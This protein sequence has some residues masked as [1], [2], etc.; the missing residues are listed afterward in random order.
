MALA[1]VRAL[2]QY[3]NEEAEDSE[4]TDGQL[5]DILNSVNGDYNIA[6]AQVWRIKAGR[7]ADLVNMTEGSSSRQWSNAHKQ[8][9][10]MTTHYEGISSDGGSSGGPVARIRKIVRS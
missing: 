6:A 8:A 2:R 4:F 10:E 9:L 5:Q 7:Y 3:T 1:D